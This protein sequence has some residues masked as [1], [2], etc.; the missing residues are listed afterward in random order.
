MNKRITW[1]H[2]E[3]GGGGTLNIGGWLANHHAVWRLTLKEYGLVE[4]RSL[5]CPL[6]GSNPDLSFLQDY[7]E[8]FNI[9]YNRER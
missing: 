7:P 6:N 3:P 9:Y 8:L 2:R 5:V 1:Y 4:P